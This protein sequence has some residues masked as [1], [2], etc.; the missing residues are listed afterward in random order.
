VKLIVVPLPLE[1]SFEHFHFQLSGVLV[2]WLNLL[3]IAHPLEATSLF[4]FVVVY[5]WMPLKQPLRVAHLVE[6]LY[7]LGLLS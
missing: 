6:A 5:L 7:C 2:Y 4:G 1:A 3:E